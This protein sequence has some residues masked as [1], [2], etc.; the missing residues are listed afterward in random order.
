MGGRKANERWIGRSADDGKIMRHFPPKARQSSFF[1][2][3]RQTSETAV[4][5]TSKSGV[6]VALDEPKIIRA[7]Q[8]PR[9]EFI[10][11]AVSRDIRAISGL[12]FFLFPRKISLTPAGG[13]LPDCGKL[14]KNFTSPIPWNISE[15]QNP[16]Q[17]HENLRPQNDSAPEHDNSIRTKC[18]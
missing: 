4:T 2:L 7:T 14:F 9:L 10:N 17:N 6:T 13:R 5:S 18:H 8:P 15:P 3:A 1:P 11:S 12:M 16:P